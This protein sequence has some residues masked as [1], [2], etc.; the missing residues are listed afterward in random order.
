[1]PLDI[2]TILDK[3]GAAVAVYR[4]GT[5]CPMRQFLTELTELER[6]KAYKLL[7]RFAEY[8]EIQN[9][10]QFKKLEKSDEI[11]EF[12]PT[13]SVRLLCFFGDRESK[14]TIILVHGVK[15]KRWTHRRPDV[16]KVQRIRKIY[17]EEGRE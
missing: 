8:G 2:E 14:R 16:E 10:E 13:S 9:T 7:Q 17:V 11:W 15:K 3:A 4:D 5:S 12:K 1:M 6:K